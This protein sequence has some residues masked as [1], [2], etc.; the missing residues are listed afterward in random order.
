E[1]QTVMLAPA[2]GFYATPGLGK[3]EVRIAYVLKKEDLGNAVK[4]IEEALKVYPGR[5]E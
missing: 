4:C 5:M 1:G 2:S 3:Q